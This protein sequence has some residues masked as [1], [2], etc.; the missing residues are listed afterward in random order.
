MPL[1]WPTVPTGFQF[2]PSHA[3]RPCINLLPAVR[4][5]PPTYRLVPTGQSRP[6]CALKPL[7]E[8]AQA[9]PFH[10]AK[11]IAVTPPMLVKDP[12]AQRR[13]LNRARLC[14]PPLK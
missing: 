14:A 8:P 10:A 13:L 9:E 11:R 7:P 6:P 5:L 1:I 12:V 2:A 3:V 4:K